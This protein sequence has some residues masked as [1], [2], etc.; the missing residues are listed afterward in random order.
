MFG[1]GFES[2]HLHRMIRASLLKGAG[3]FCCVQ[4]G[5]LVH[6]R[7]QEMALSQW[8]EDYL[9]ARVP[10]LPKVQPVAGSRHC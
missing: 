2:P 6:V 8:K 10:G 5:E 1:Q 7:G 3:H 9:R 4:R